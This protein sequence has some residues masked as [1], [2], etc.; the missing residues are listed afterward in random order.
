M[1]RS[2]FFKKHWFTGDSGWYFMAIGY[3]YT[4]PKIIIYKLWLFGFSINL[5]CDYSRSKQYQLPTR[6]YKF[7]QKHK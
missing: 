2:F 1:K 3:V 7:I 5:R 4:Y 6:F